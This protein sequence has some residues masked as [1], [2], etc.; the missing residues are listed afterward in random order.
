MPFSF[1]VTFLLSE[2][3]L[4][5]GTTSKDR[6]PTFSEV[7]CCLRHNTQKNNIVLATK[8]ISIKLKTTK[9][10]IIKIA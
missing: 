10:N 4:V 5:E 1:V 8:T 2:F 3:V 7:I 6:P 9:E